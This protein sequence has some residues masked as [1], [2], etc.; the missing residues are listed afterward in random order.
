M[1]YVV[2]LLLIALN[3]MT[4]PAGVFSPVRDDLL[5]VIMSYLLASTVGAACFFEMHPPLC[6]WSGDQQQLV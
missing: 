2:H 3:L 4:L 1:S 6:C 5:V